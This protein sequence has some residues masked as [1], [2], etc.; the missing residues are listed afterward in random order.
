MHKYHGNRFTSP[1]TIFV[2]YPIIIHT[3]ILHRIPHNLIVAL[4]PRNISYS[5]VPCTAVL[6]RILQAVQVTAARR[7]HTHLFTPRAVSLV[8]VDQALQVTLPRCSDCDLQSRFAAALQCKLISG[9]PSYRPWRTELPPSVATS[10]PRSTA[11]C[12][13][14]SLCLHAS[15][16]VSP[17][18]SGQPCR[19]RYNTQLQCP[20]VAVFSTRNAGS[21]D[22][23]VFLVLRSRSFAAL[24]RHQ[25]AAMLV[26]EL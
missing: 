13:M 5:V 24:C 8:C 17:L 25:W 4:L 15:C 23:T 12:S 10:H 16:A 1:Q 3:T 2:S 18:V 26:C 11:S 21:L 22:T 7:R 6:T 14:L 9:I 20:C 19:I